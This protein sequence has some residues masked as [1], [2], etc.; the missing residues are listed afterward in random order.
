MNM[1]TIKKLFADNTWLFVVG[2][3]GLMFQSTIQKTVAALFI[4]LGNDY[5]EDD[6]ILLN[7]KPARIVRVGL[8]KSTFFLYNIKNGIVTGGT[9]LVIQN[10]RLSSMNLEKPLQKIDIEN[11]SDK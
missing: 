1:E 4:F 11:I 8:W 5:H 10:E 7:G 9:K 6:I 3:I 2:I